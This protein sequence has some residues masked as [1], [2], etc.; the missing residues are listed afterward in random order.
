MHHS[1][2]LAAALSL[3]A[4]APPPLATVAEQSGFTRTG[5]YDEVQRLCPAFEAAYRGK[6]HCFTFGTTPEGRPMLAL[7][8]RTAPA[9]APVVLVQGGIHAGEIDGKDAGFWLLRDLLDRKAGVEGGKSVLQSVK[10][11]FV[12]VFNVDGHERF[13]PNNRPNQV[14]P[15][16][17][18]YRVTAQNLNLNRDYAKA[19]APE[20]RAM[21]ALLNRFDPIVYQDLHVTDGAQFQHD[22]SVW[23]EPR[24]AG[25]EVLRLQG[26]PF[27]AALQAE[28]KAGG[29]LPIDFYPA[30]IK[31]DDPTSGF[32]AGIPPPRFSHGYWPV[33]NRYVVLVE[34]HSWKDYATRVKA[35]RDVVLATLRYVAAHG[36]AMVA[37]AKAADLA[38]ARGEGPVELAYEASGAPVTFDFQGYEYKIAPSEISGQPWIHYDQG[39]PQIWKVPLYT[40]VTPSLTVQLGPAAGYLVPAGVAGAVQERLAAHGLKLTRLEKALRGVKVSAFRITSVKYPPASFEGRTMPQVHGAWVEETRDLPP[41]SLFVPASQPGRALVVHLLEPTGPDSL[42]A[43]GLFNAWLER[44]D[45]MERYVVE[46]AARKM[47]AADPRLRADFDAALKADAGFAASADQ[48]LELFERRH[49]SWDE[50]FNLY[51]I[52]RVEA[53]PAG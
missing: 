25:R 27:N 11:V 17:M 39:K 43:W 24:L 23:V 28:L 14:G 41:G 30:F 47:I 44:K 48:R 35:T 19:D 20:M 46:D 53:P 2:L 18:G 22:V 10:L 38:D 29:H 21:L 42:L 16:E 8:L 32:R 5:R 9:G 3:G 7:E 15:A 34:T 1:L 26:V 31:E 12:P 4:G 52:F 51:P 49:P 45:G 33:R 37:A 50:H 13:G 40:E 36:A 6:V